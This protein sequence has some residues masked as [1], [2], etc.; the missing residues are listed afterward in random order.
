MLFSLAVTRR[1]AAN[2][3]FLKETTDLPYPK[4]G[5]RAWFWQKPTILSEHT[6]EETS[7]KTGETSMPSKTAWAC[8]PPT[9]Q[10][11]FESV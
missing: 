2:L 9:F 10:A 5:I 4:H 8:E 1:A 6:V 7:H 11:S 3:W